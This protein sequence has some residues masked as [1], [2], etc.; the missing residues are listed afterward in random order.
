VS[1]LTAEE[2]L[3]KALEMRKSV[4]N[5]RKQVAAL[6]DIQHDEHFKSSLSEGAPSLL[7]LHSGVLQLNIRI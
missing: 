5:V 2:G 3:T 1:S 7:L 6:K 4:E